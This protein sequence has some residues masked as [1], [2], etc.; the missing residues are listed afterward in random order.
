MLLPLPDYRTG[1]RGLGSVPV[2]GMNQVL[3]PQAVEEKG[4]FLNFESD[5]M[6]GGQKLWYDNANQASVSR[7]FHRFNQFIQ[8]VD[9]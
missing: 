7:E 3:I 8:S 1:L 9:G 6:Q 5:G 4:Q 2:R